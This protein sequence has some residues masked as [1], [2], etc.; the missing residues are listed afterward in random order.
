[1][2][3][4]SGGQSLLSRSVPRFT[5]LP[6]RVIRLSRRVPLLIA[7]M[8]V[9]GC[10]TARSAG[11]PPSV[12]DTALAVIRVQGISDDIW[13]Y[14]QVSRPE[15]SARAGTR[16]SRLISPT[17][18]QER[19]NGRFA[20][21]TL[22][23]LD[24]VY[25]EALPQD[26][27]VTWLAMRWEMEALTGWPAFHWTRLWDLSPGRSAFD[28]AL[29][30]FSLQRVAEIGDGQRFLSLL[31]SVPPIA[32]DLRVEY[33]ERARRG[34]RLPRIAMDRAIAHVRSLIA[35]A[36]ASP[37]GLPPDFAAPPESAWRWQLSRDVPSAI[38]DRVNPAL[39]SLATWLEQQRDSAPDEIGLGRLP[40]G[41]AHYETLL[42]YHSTIDVTPED[43]H[44][45][46]LRE[47][48]RI[49]ALAAAARQEAGLPVDRDSLR[50]VLTTDSQYVVRDAGTIPEIAAAMH[51]VLSSELDTLFGPSPT[52]RLSIGI[53]PESDESSALAT[54]QPAT[55]VEPTALYL[56][57]PVKLATR[58]LVVLPSLIAGDLMPGLH[59]Q[60]AT[61]FERIALPLSRR[62]SE[63][64]GYV[65]GWQL[66]ALQVTDSLSRSINA[67]QR[68]GIRLRE[69]AAACGL[70]ID[71][72]IN[73]FGWTRD[74][75]LAFLRAYLPLEDADLEREFIVEAIEGPGAL[76]A[77]TLGARELRGLRQWAQRELGARFTLAAFHQ[78]LLR[79]GSVPLP[80]LGSHLERWIWEQNR[81]APVPPDARR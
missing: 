54:Y 8:T 46:G 79:V 15:I 53:Q 17:N 2:P 60:R 35:P 52:T 81:P 42:R 66:Y 57:H 5:S 1:M 29:E 9:Q 73:A 21:N 59:H 20:R 45:I 74:D 78:E 10:A 12:A 63:H 43:A 3:F 49:A 37:F 19:R 28:R 36:S 56:I 50:A 25:V 23:A 72:G 41:T 68:F 26:A 48:A 77:G 80:V 18:V 7:V 14:V 30:V 62:F 13:R 51:A 38:T 22:S 40:G 71:T 44:T 16:L 67:A 31:N 61:Q 58:S 76:G 69:L 75:A 39:D 55:V 4:S 27:Y 64:S 33:A 34:I 24:E 11:R 65:R 6:R 70:V 47:V 32:R